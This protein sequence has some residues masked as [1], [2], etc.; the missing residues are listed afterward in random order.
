MVV[1]Y[2]IFVCSTDHENFDFHRGDKFCL[3]TKEQFNNH[4]SFLLVMLDQRVTRRITLKAF[5]TTSK[6]L[7]I[8]FLEAT[9]T[10][11]SFFSNI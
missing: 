11:C 3:M 5:R 2:T 9:T 7:K 1:K 4:S 6:H 8:N 10:T